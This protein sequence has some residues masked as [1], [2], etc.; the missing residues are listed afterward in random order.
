MRASIIFFVFSVLLQPVL[1]GQI[2]NH[3][4]I[5]E[6]YGGGGNSGAL[7]KSDFVELYNPTDSPVTLSGWS[8]Q[9]ASATGAFTQ[10]TIL[11]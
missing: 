1:R 10:T 5:S 3:V 6:V 7:W 2:A 8:I 4:V 9:Y 11:S